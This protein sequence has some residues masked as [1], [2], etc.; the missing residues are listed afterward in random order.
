MKTALL[1]LATMLLGS[2]ITW[3]V[4]TVTHGE[5][6][7]AAQAIQAADHAERLQ[8]H[9]VRARRL[10]EAFSKLSETDA[11]LTEI[12]AELRAKVAAKPTRR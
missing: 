6:V 8:D 11:R 12:L 9:E 5:T 1:S 7:H 3:L 4:A 2:G 10:E